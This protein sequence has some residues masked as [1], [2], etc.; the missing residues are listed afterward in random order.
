[1]KGLT[2]RFISWDLLDIILVVAVTFSLTP[3]CFWFIFWGWGGEFLQANRGLVLNLIQALL[4]GGLTLVLVKGKYKIKFQQFGLR[5]I[6]VDTALKYGVMGGAFLCLMV[7]G[8]NNFTHSL[9]AEILGAAPPT[10]QVIKDL[11]AT[12]TSGLFILHGILIV[13]IAPITEEIFFRGLIYPYC[14]MKLGLGKGMVVS[15][16]VFGAAHFSW[17]VFFPTFLG[18]VI[19]AWIYQRTNSLYPVI[20]AHGV[21]N[22]IIVLLVYIIWGLGVV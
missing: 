13:V 3:L 18:G 7:V 6:T 15:G 16:M 4:L 5:R 14:R 17:W 20:L 11:L 8:I 21:W 9:L 22:L 10:Q 1:M 12:E 2:D 19:L